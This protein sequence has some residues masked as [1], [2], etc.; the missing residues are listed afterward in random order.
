MTCDLESL[1]RCGV[2]RRLVAILSAM[3]AVMI[4]QCGNPSCP[5]SFRYLK[6][7]RLFRLENDPTL[8]FSKVTTAEYFWLCPRCSSTMTL[9]L[10]EDG[11]V[12]PVVLPEPFR[13]VPDGVALTSADREKGLLLRSVSSS[14][15]EHLG[16]RRGT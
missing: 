7:G 16:G 14:L 1:H 11:S 2:R 3:G 15:P 13:G 5:A 8:R 12:I 6:E 10:S 4:A 9:N